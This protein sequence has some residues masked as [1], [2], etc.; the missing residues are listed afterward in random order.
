MLIPPR[1]QREWQSPMRIFPPPFCD[2]I[3]STANGTHLAASKKRSF[4]TV[5]CDNYEL[6][7]LWSAGSPNLICQKGSTKQ[8]KIVT[9]ILMCLLRQ[10]PKTTG[11]DKEEFKITDK[12]RVGLHLARKGYRW[13]NWG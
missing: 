6:Y 4:F 2:F 9:G 5:Q 11:K 8:Q 1:T 10:A 13:I 3:S 12:V 7:I